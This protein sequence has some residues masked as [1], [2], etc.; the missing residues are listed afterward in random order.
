MRKT[1]GSNTAATHSDDNCQAQNREHVRIPLDPVTPHK[2]TKQFESFR[3]IGSNNKNM[4]V[5]FSDTTASSLLISGQ[6]KLCKSSAADCTLAHENKRLFLH[7][8]LF[9]NVALKTAQ[10]I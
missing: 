4:S 2:S 7:L 1:P 3:D 6:K 9:I 10:L 8:L 5:C